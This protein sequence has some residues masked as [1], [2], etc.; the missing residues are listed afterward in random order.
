MDTASQEIFY[1]LEERVRKIHVMVAAIDSLCHNQPRPALYNYRIEL[2][3]WSDFFV[4]RM[5]Q[6]IKSPTKYKLYNLNLNRRIEEFDTLCNKLS[7]FCIDNSIQ[8]VTLICHKEF[9][10]ETFSQFIKNS[11]ISYTK[12]KLNEAI[13]EL[14]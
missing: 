11:A 8:L 1:L 14:E 4:E 3:T 6:L 9:D 5:A 12:S 10:S 13:K 7:T 2:K